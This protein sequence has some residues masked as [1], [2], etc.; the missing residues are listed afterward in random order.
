[1]EVNSLA[2][3]GKYVEKI[4]RG[5]GYVIML[6]E[7]KKPL[8]KIVNK[9]RHA[10]IYTKKHNQIK[11]FYLLFK[12]KFFLTYG[13]QFNDIGFG[14]SINL[15]WF[16]CI[17]KSD[18]LEQILF[19]YKDGTIYFITPEEWRSFVES[20]NT[21]RMQHGGEV[22]TCVRI[23]ILNRWDKTMTTQ[24]L[25]KWINKPGISEKLK[26]CLTNALSRLIN[27]WR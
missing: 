21:I 3:A 1:M 17:E 9:G 24:E 19:C 6:D 11:V 15:E 22:T 7:N 23:D 10:I 12:R 18:Y 27:V 5:R 4:L 2:E 14:E 16:K 26:Q 13:K 20:N 25:T 8:I